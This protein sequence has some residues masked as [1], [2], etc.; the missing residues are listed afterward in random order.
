MKKEQEKPQSIMMTIRSILSSIKTTVT[1]CLL[2]AL[3][4]LAGTLIKQNAS[5]DEYLHLYGSALTRFFRALGLFDLYHS[6]GFILLLLLLSMNIIFCSVKNLPGVWK[7]SS[8]PRKV[9]S[10]KALS[11]RKGSQTVISPLSSSDTEQR[12]TRVIEGMFGAVR[13]FPG[14]GEVALYGR[15]GAFSRFGPYVTH[16]GVLLILAGGM[17]GSLLGFKGF[18]NVA[19][20]ESASSIWLFGSTEEYPLGFTVRCDKFLVEYYDEGMPKEYESELTVLEGT[21]EVVKRSIQVNH[22]LSHRGVTFYQ[23]SYGEDPRAR[24]DLLVVNTETKEEASFSATVGSTLAMPGSKAVIRLLSY[25]PNLTMPGG[26][27]SGARPM[28]LGP[29][30]QVLVFEGKK[31]SR[32]SWLI[33]KHPDRSVNKGPGYSITLKGIEPK[34]YTGLQVTKDPGTPIV[35]AGCTLMIF[36]LVISFY[37]SHRQIWL[38]VQ[39]RKEGSKVTVAGW[40]NKDS[41]SFERVF[42]RV[43]AEIRQALSPSDRPSGGQK[44]KR[45]V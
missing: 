10:Q 38:V 8:G 37:F 36:G 31:H 12:V 6:T 19:E 23:A 15:K 18:V 21:E 25:N 40:S 26:T 42:D 22:P 3:I 20:G 41:E 5:P 16:L 4:S 14:E 13:S 43:V 45:A 29:A 7:L 24:V 9:P 17:V 27:Q 28:S 1:L 35:W 2:L 33:L 30:V 11:R 39:P 44:W 34:F 32:P